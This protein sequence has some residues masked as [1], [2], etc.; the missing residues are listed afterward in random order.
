MNINA[1]VKTTMVITRNESGEESTVLLKYENA[2]TIVVDM[3]NYEQ[4]ADTEQN[5]F[6]QYIDQVEREV[7]FMN[8]R[9]G[10]KVTHINVEEEV[11]GFHHFILKADRDGLFDNT[12]YVTVYCD[13]N[14]ELVFYGQWFNRTEEEIYADGHF[15][16]ENDGLRFMAIV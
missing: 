10:F 11:E 7:S 3:F 12:M 9:N 1:N 4:D 8:G 15:V 14:Q 16:H 13:G 2:P 6:T 5:E